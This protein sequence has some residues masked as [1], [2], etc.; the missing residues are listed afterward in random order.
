MLI[1]QHVSCSTFDTVEGPMENKSE[2]NRV[3]VAYA[4]FRSVHATR[5]ITEIT[6]ILFFYKRLKLVREL[7]SK[8]LVIQNK[9]NHRSSS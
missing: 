8:A 1:A 4:Y 3:L 6:S 9:D 2:Y 7:K 5:T